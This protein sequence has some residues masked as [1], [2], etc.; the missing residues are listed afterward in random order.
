MLWWKKSKW[1]NGKNK[2]QTL[3]SRI[4]EFSTWKKFVVITNPACSN[5]VRRL[6]WCRDKGHTDNKRKGLKV[7]IW[8]Q[9]VIQVDIKSLQKDTRNEG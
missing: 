4:V 5:E 3:E 6:K 8:G 2:T 7:W 9:E 1:E